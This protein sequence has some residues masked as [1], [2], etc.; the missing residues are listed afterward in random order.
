MMTRMRDILSGVPKSE[1][2]D[3]VEHPSSN[4][5]AME[6]RIRDI[7]NE[8]VTVTADLERLGLKYN[9][10][11]D[12]LI[13]S[14]LTLCDRLKDSGIRAEPVRIPPALEMGE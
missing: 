14:Q 13:K 10:L 11:R 7:E 8:L 9:S 6:S 12:T 5:N 1:P 3:V 2:A 4:L